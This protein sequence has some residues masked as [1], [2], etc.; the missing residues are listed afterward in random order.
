MEIKRVITGGL[1]TFAAGATMVLGAGATTTL[2]DFVTVDGNTMTSPYIVIGD[3]AAAADTL[4]AADVAVALAGQ[5]TETVSVSGATATMAVSDGAAIKTKSENLYVTDASGN[6]A[7]NA[8]PLDGFKFTYKE[9]PVLLKTETFKQD[10]S[11]T[12]EVAQRIYVGAQTVGFNKDNNADWTD[13][14]LNIYLEKNKALYT[15]E[16]RF[17]PA[18]ET[19]QIADKTIN[20]L[21]KEFVFGSASGQAGDKLT[22]FESS[23]TKTVAAGESI[24]V[25][26]G[27]EDYVITVVGINDAGTST[28]IDIN[29]ESD[30]Y[31]DED[32]IE[33]G[34][35]SAHVK[36]INAF[37][38]PVE[39]GSVE[40]FIGSQSMVLEDGEEVTLGGDEV[41]GTIVRV[42]NTTTDIREV[43]VTY[44]V[45]DKDYMEVGES[46]TDPVFDAFD[47]S[48]GGIYP[49]LDDA[50]KDMIKVETADTD[51]VLTFTNADDITYEQVILYADSSAI[52]LNTDGTASTTVNVRNNQTITEGEFVVVT[53][54]S[55]Y[56]YILEFTDI[57]GNSGEEIIT[58][59]DVS[60]GGEY[61]ITA[62]DY[63]QT[64]GIGSIDVSVTGFSASGTE[65]VALNNTKG[66]INDV[67]E[68]W[69]ESGANITIVLS[70]ATADDTFGGAIHIT[71]S[72]FETEDQL[73]EDYFNITVGLGSSTISSIGLTNAL[74]DQGMESDDDGDWEYGLSQAGTYIVLDDTDDDDETITIYTPDE[75]T[76]VYVAFGTSPTFAGGSGAAA[77]TVQQAVQI[78]NSISKFESQ[79]TADSTLSRDLVL[80]GGPCANGLVAELLEMSAT[81]PDCATEFTAEHPT[82][83][84]ITVVEDAFG[85]GQKA[86][87]V[88]G[89]NRDTTR[90]LAVKVMQGTL[91]YS[92]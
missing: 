76:P 7:F 75:P 17:S 92:A 61:K 18:V 22:L 39:S 70:N 19:D 81:N 59:T 80:L 86:L 36:A 79:V 46:F 71:E 57:S 20:L 2:G 33:E 15:Y 66:P 63:G 56:T 1:A 73:T 10:D 37:K 67:A 84:V 74:I 32:D 60:T 26:S 62:D 30:T 23:Q 25:T 8:S 5:A 82:E 65:S 77:G 38:F 64:V 69:T 9:L 68:F 16:M 28:T 27:G 90:D 50:S 31:E 88:A 91:E 4:A 11:D 6:N 41:D 87:V 24:T 44:E 85:S 55:E 83:G 14:Q 12:V 29:G 21:G 3:N 47:I 53:D 89:V 34:E 35:L 45:Q 51:V 54:G 48:L 43:E 40:L 78:K 49:A 42:T 58:L 52:E 72:T 13:P